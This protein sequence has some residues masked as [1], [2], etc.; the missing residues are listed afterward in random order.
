MNVITTLGCSIPTCPNAHHAKGY[1]QTHYN[2]SIRSGV[3]IDAPLRQVRRAG[4]WSLECEKSDCEKKQYARGFCH[5][6][7]YYQWQTNLTYAAIEWILNKQD[8]RCPICQ[9]E[10]PGSRGWLAEHNHDCCDGYFFCGR[11]A[12][13]MV[14]HRCN[15]F[16]YRTEADVIRAAEF[17]QAVPI[18][19]SVPTELFFDPDRPIGKP[20]LFQPNPSGLLLL[21]SQLPREEQKAA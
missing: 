5:N 7:Y 17:F 14:C 21:T 18:G 19:L 1:C 11:C 15:V 2:R 16:R 8:G 9:R 12:R 10:D 20:D 4:V 6:H 3:A 13:G